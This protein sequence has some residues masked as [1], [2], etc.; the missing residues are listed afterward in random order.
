MYAEWLDRCWHWN[1]GQLTFMHVW[2]KCSRIQMF[3]QK[4]QIEMQNIPFKRIPFKPRIFL[5]RDY[6]KCKKVKCY[7]INGSFNINCKLF[8]IF[9]HSIYPGIEA[10]IHFLFVM[11]KLS[12]LKKARL[13]NMRALLAFW[14]QWSVFL[15]YC[16]GYHWN[17]EMAVYI[18]EINYGRKGAHLIYKLD[19]ILD[20]NE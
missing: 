6:K 1:A 10:I 20:F 16:S 5:L 7:N 4:V 19:E 14:E 12:A 18:L 2:W 13:G 17:Y 8:E 9:K 3:W 15:L 11:V